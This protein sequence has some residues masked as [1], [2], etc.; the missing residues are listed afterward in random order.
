[1]GT[2]EGK[3]ERREREGQKRKERRRD[4][5]KAGKTEDAIPLGTAVAS[6]SGGWLPRELGSCV[7]SKGVK[8]SPS[9][10]CCGGDTGDVGTA[11][12]AVLLGAVLGSAGAGAV[13][14]LLPHRFHFL[15]WAGHM[16][17]I[18]GL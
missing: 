3:R 7:P 15:S 5:R 9:T 17:V 12:G 18:W 14:T 16:A 2:G 13:A 8:Q 10:G 1:M 11:T 4:R 6:N